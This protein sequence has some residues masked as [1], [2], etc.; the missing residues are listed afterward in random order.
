MTDESRFTEAVHKLTNE[1]MVQAP[2]AGRTHYQRHDALISQLRKAAI[3]SSTNDGGAGKQEPRERIPFDADAVTKYENLTGQIASWYL[4][5]MSVRPARAISPEAQLSRVARVFSNGIQAG[6]V[7]DGQAT[8]IANRWDRWVTTIEDKLAGLKQIEVTAPCPVCEFEW[9]IDGE[10]LQVRAL[11]VT[12]KDDLQGGLSESFAR[13]KLCGE[14]WHGTAA[15]RKLRQL[16]DDAESR[17][18][19]PSLA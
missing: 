14:L 5:V 15:L 18:D 11:T 9:I 6:K 16:I 19:T 10:G 4:E 17:A 7:N 1:H 12:Y 3:P 2:A 8:V 13:C